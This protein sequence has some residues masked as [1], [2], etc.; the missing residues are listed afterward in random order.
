MVQRS[1]EKEQRF[2]TSRSDEVF[3]RTANGLLSSPRVWRFQLLIH[4]KA[5]LFAGEDLL[6]LLEGVVGFVDNHDAVSVHP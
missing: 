3:T 6:R 1:I 2:S 5:D 4:D